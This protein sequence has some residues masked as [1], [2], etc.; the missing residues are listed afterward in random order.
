MQL[1][2]LSLDIENH[3]SRRS[4]LTRKCSSIRRLGLA[5]GCVVYCMVPTREA[6]CQPTP[7]ESSQNTAVQSEALPIQLLPFVSGLKDPTALNFAPDGSGTLYVSERQGTIRA[8]KNGKLLR[9]SYLDIE[10]FVDSNGLQGFQGFGFPKDFATNRLLFVNYTDK[11]G[12][13][14]VASFKAA[15][16]EIDP[17][18]IYVRL[19]I[20]QPFGTS[21]TSEIAFGPDGFLYVGVADSSTT[22]G[23]KS[24][25]QD[26]KSLF[27]KVLRIDVAAP[28]GYKIPDDNPYR[29]AK[30]KAPEIWAA[31]FQKPGKLTF[32]TLNGTLFMT[33]AGKSNEEELNIVTKG[34]N[35]GWDLKEGITCRN[36]SDCSSRDFVDPIASLDRR[37]GKSLSNGFRYRGKLIP[38]LTDKYVGGD[39]GGNELWTLEKSPNDR[40]VRNKIFTASERIVSLGE[41]AKGELYI[42]TTPGNVL[43]LVP[44]S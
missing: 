17:E 42:L 21:N 5:L 27:G 24:F 32:D 3:N 15:L 22:Q 1:N 2:R 34:G 12:D 18:T 29:D 36:G 8:I 9:G 16:D 39:R 38:A 44:A 7:S 13:L 6:W 30:D 25:A 43:R 35:Y 10:D 40:W 14:V 31:G 28:E 26:M 33:D 23:P 11:Q 4:L 41:D 20:V 19:K 37:D